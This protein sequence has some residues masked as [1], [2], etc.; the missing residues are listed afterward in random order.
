LARRTGNDLAPVAPDLA[1]QV[2]ERLR[3]ARAD[4]GW[5]LARTGAAAGISTSYLSSLENGNNLASL[6]ILA[7]LA[8]VLDLSLNAVLRDLGS[9]DTATRRDLATDGHG[10]QD[11]GGENLQLTVRALAASPGESGPS[12]VAITGSDLFVYALSGSIDVIIDDEPFTLHQG[13]SL[14]AEL[15][16]AA[17]YRVPGADRA[18]SIWATAPAARSPATSE[19]D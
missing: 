2:G 4:L 11:L 5:T 9:A 12:P 1:R 17:A 7:R 6:P 18:I 19:G 8:N 3:A 13:D 10:V 14:D 15:P 16:S